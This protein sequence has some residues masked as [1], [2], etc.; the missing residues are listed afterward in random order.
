MLTKTL[1]INK[2]DEYTWAKA[3]ELVSKGICEN[4]SRLVIDSLEKEISR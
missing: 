2:F 3:E 4:M 1:C